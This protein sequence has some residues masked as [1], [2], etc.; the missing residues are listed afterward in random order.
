MLR[1][2]FF[3]FLLGGLIALE[4]RA[5]DPVPLPSEDEWTSLPDFYERN[6]FIN[7]G[8]P[9]VEDLP[10]Y[11]EETQ[12]YL[13]MIE[14]FYVVS[15]D[16]DDFAFVAQAF[17]VPVATFRP[18]SFRPAG[19]ND[20]DDIFSDD[21]LPEATNSSSYYVDTIRP[22]FMPG[23]PF[24]PRSI[25]EVKLGDDGRGRS[26]FNDPPPKKEEKAPEPKTAK[27]DDKEDKNAKDKSEADEEMAKA[28]KINAPTKPKAIIP[29]S[30]EETLQALKQAVHDLGLQ[31]QLNFESNQYSQTTTKMPGVTPPVNPANPTALETN[32][33]SKPLVPQVAK[34]ETKSEAQKGQA[35]KTEAPKAVKPAT[36]VKKKPAAKIPA[37][38]KPA[39]KAPPKVIEKTPL[40]I[41]PPY[42]IAPP[43][44]APS[45][46][47][48]DEI[49]IEKAGPTKK[50]L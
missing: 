6:G 2:F 29:G 20:M 26:L 36:P 50:S 31:K 16:E 49:T 22:S 42:Q 46:D 14:H 7:Y 10:R 28:G 8:P 32:P 38:K 17:S 9:L 1:A 25:E 47:D 4:A 24:Q 45:P 5:D 27:K 33:S 39:K 11:R 44:P 41:E 34:D 13:D 21:P 23:G 37:K 19:K 43:Q 30:D 15:E 3:I 35:P 40:P 12:L 48:D 18:S